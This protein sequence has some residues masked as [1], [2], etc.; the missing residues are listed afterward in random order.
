MSGE[1]RE[2][3]IETVAKREGILLP[4]LGGRFDCGPAEGLFAS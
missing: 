3:I 4:V 2:L 1:V